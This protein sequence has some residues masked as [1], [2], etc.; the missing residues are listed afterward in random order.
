MNFSHKVL[1]IKN[2]HV[3]CFGNVYFTIFNV[4]VDPDK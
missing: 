4:K 1:T 2:L 3:M